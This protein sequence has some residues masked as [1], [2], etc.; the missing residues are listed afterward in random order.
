[1][2]VSY[3]SPFVGRRQWLSPQLE[4]LGSGDSEPDWSTPVASASFFRGIKAQLLDH[5][6]VVF[7]L[8][9]VPNR[10][11]SFNVLGKSKGMPRLVL[12]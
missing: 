9:R 6:R 5:H 7:T 4:G 11:V 2:I 3:P 8:P 10:V 1:V 12:I